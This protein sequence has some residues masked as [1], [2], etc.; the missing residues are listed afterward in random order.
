MHQK[1]YPRS[2]RKQRSF[3]HE[4]KYKLNTTQLE[5]LKVQ[6]PELLAPDPHAGED[7]VYQIR[8][9]YF[10]DWQ[11]TCYFENEN[12]TEPR[13][14]F[15]IRIYNGSDAHIRLELKRK[16]LG[17]VQKRSCRIN[18]ELAESMIRGQTIPWQ[19]D[20]DPLLKKFYILQETRLLTPKIIVEYDRIP[21]VY[22]DG[23]VR[24][25]LDLNIRTSRQVEDF[26]EPEI[27]ARPIMPMDTHLLEAKF[28]QFLPDFISRIFQQKQLQRVTYSKFYY[29]RKFGDLT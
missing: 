16:E 17:M 27:S 15:R 18:R 6:L 25:T 24:V 7:G 26:F 8:S 1:V 9:L 19:E 4:L 29:C 13:E 10:D 14:K 12:G 20:M 23:N 28:D 21:F 2:G 22:P 11:N 5:I 3:R